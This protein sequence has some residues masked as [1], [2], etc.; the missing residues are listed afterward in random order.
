MNG[1]DKPTGNKPLFRIVKGNLLEISLEIVTFTD[2]GGGDTA[3]VVNLVGIMT[4]LLKG[5][6][7][8]KSKTYAASHLNNT[9]RLARVAQN[10]GSWPPMPTNSG[11]LDSHREQRGQARMPPLKDTV[12]F[13]IK[14][15]T[16]L[17]ENA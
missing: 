6:G 12:L 2:R 10:T 16:H 14:Y 13:G 8:F 3:W 1:I 9:L 5:P 17:K 7:P 4:M 11:W 15:R